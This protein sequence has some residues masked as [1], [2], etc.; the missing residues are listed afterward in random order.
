MIDTYSVK[1]LRPKY[2]QLSFVATEDATIWI[3]IDGVVNSHSQTAT[4][5]SQTVDL[6]VA[7]AAAPVAIALHE[8]GTKPPPIFTPRD[9]WSRPELQWQAKTG[10]IKYLIYHG[11]RVIKQITAIA[12]VNFYEYRLRSSLA[13]G[14]H[15]FRVESVDSY[16]RETT[17]ANWTFQVFK[18]PS[19]SA[20]IS[21]AQDE[22]TLTITVDH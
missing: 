13:E 4:G 18:M 8:G 19:E 22:T 14:W 17:R 2:L 21:V 3:E 16:D 9:Y 6:K 5:M 12:N 11:D 10:A 1:Y 7:D 15:N 20:G